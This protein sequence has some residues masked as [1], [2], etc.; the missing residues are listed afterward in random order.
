MYLNFFEFVKIEENK[1]EFT[2][3][4]SD[5]HTPQVNS[6]KR[7][8]VAKRIIETFANA[9]DTKPL[10]SEKPTSSTPLSASKL[11]QIPSST[12]TTTSSTLSQSLVSRLTFKPTSSNVAKTPSPPSSNITVTFKDHQTKL[13]SSTTGDDLESNK[14]NSLKRRI[15][16][17][18]SSDETV[19][20]SDSDERSFKYKSVLSSPQ[21]ESSKSKI[22]SLTA[23]RTT[24]LNE[25]LSLKTSAESVS[26]STITN[27]TISS[28]LESL[29]IEVKAHDNE[30]KSVFN[31]IRTTTVPSRVA[32][33][34]PAAAAQ[35]LADFSKSAK[36]NR[37]VNSTMISLN[38]SAS[39]VGDTKSS[40]IV[41]VKFEAKRQ[42][43]SS[44]N[45]SNSAPA[46][47]IVVLNAKNNTKLHMDAATRPAS[48]NIHDRIKFV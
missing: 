13:V 47:K 1:K 5:S 28:N 41:P 26:K 38:K 19:S 34:E 37:T 23:K 15:N 45:V 17:V 9:T 31:R 33:Q 10:V 46:S 29:R 8:D 35:L 6:K 7:C 30:K 3:S 16:H 39:S 22:I 4:S 21:N 24:S 32:T 48:K 20:N 11:I 14:Q 36:V 44:F 40:K 43:V 27:R 25:P 18:Y 2:S 42:P 12:N